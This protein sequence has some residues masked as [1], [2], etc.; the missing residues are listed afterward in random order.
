M[1]SS[2][3]A[4]IGASGFVGTS[5]I[6]SLL[7]QGETR[8]RAI[9]RA[10]R[11]FASLAR[12]GDRIDIQL[13]DAEDKDSLSKALEGAR[14]AVNLTTGPPKGI[15]NSTESIL[16]ACRHAKVQRL[17]H[18]SSAVVYGRVDVPNLVDH[19][20]PARSLW[21][22]YARAKATC[23]QWL[24]SHMDALTPEIVVLRPGIVWGPRSPHTLDIAMSLLQSNAYL[25]HEGK[26]I[27]NSIYIDNLIGCIQACIEHCSGVAG[28][29]NV[30]DDPGVTWREL[31]IALASRL[32]VDTACIANVSKLPITGKIIVEYVQQ[33]P[34]INE[35]YHRLKR[36]LPDGLKSALKA[37]LAGAYE[38]RRMVNEFPSKVEVGREMWHLQQVRHRLPTKKFEHVFN[39]TPTVSFD[40]GIARTALWLSASGY[41]EPQNVSHGYVKIS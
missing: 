23:E 37:R 4:I 31:Y 13:A 30:A 29:Y 34:W 28:F 26:G 9:V 40:E 36:N 2:T 38:Y 5:L 3:I 32:D 25:V 10:Y 24:Q 8:L 18:L 41:R 21:M 17:I 20:A 27:F 33:L 1:S 12:Y 7:L 35:F 14:V 22:P 19:S 6:E 11:N 15:V 16:A 39:Y